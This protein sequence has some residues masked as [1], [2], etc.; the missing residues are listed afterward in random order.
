MPKDLRQEGRLELAIRAVQTG[1]IISV[2]RAAHLYNVPR[3]T[4]RDRLTG[5][6]Q[7]SITDRTKRKLTE[8]EEYT[9]LQW[10]LSMDKRGAPL[11]PTT[12][13]NMA[14]LL[15]ANRDASK[16]SSTVGK[17]WVTKF[18]RRHDVLKTRFSRRYDH[19]R[20]L[21]EDPK[22]IQEWFELVRSTIK[23]WGITD[24][25][26]YNFDETGFAMGTIATAKVITQ[27]ERTSRLSG[28]EAW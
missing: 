19:Q 22:K 24:E 2:Q 27:A 11:R 26:I 20:A 17:N 13:Q 25:D 18:V 28:N 6:K 9:L 23:E 3:T 10:I 5:I 1:Q 12:V 21:C 15:L 7:R 16:P 4:L 14:N 8:T